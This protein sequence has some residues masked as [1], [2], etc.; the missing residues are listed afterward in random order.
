M[1]KYRNYDV[2]DLFVFGGFYYAIVITSYGVP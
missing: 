2:K 1:F